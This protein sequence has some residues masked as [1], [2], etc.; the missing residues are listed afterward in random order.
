MVVPV[1]V[2]RVEHE[3]QAYRRGLPDVKPVLA[4]P[5]GMA[6]PGEGW[7]TDAFESG[8]RVSLMPY[9]VPSA[10]TQIECASP[11]RS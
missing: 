7:A 4:S 6:P 10:A 2:A 8:E 3:L 1:M 5:A 9:G 11:C